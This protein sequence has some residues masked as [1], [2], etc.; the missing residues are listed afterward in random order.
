MCAFRG[1]SCYIEKHNI[2]CSG[3]VEKDSFLYDFF[4]TLSSRL[5]NQLLILSLSA[6]TGQAE[7]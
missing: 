4:L 6:R 3:S 1:P 2:Y 5:P 7:R